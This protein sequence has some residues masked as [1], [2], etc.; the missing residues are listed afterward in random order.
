L[1][2]STISESTPPGE[3]AEP[4]VTSE[5]EVE[6]LSLPVELASLLDGSGFVAIVRS[7]AAPAQVYRVLRS[8][9]PN[10][11][12]KIGPGLSQERERLRW[13]QDRL[14]VPRVEFYA[15]ESG[16][17]FMLLSEVPG[18]PAD[19]QAW[20]DDTSALMR[21]VAGAVR[22]IHGLP[23]ADCPFTAP[24]EDLLMAAERTVR[25]GLVHQ[26]EFSSGY[27]HLTPEALLQRALA[28]RPTSN[29]IVFTHG[30]CCLPNILI[31]PDGSAG[32]VDLGGAGLSDAWRDLAL[33]ARSI[34]R[35]FGEIWVRAF[36]A[37]YGC[38]LDEPRLQFFAL[39]DQLTMMRRR[40]QG[41]ASET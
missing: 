28:I 27:R 19:A 36:F 14:V 1:A 30:D 34:Q 16:T 11:Y 33:V 10:V 31:A 15:E 23:L 40:G 18:R 3:D 39:L 29:R 7:Y 6:A 2:E 5:L 37:A 17:A 4:L 13:L 9:A 41:G 32:V 8:G 25:Q 20:N 12:L 24:V 22:T 38:D 26:S 21:A 35:A